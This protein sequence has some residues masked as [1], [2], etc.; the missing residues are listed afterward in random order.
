MA[1][2]CCS[3]RLFCHRM[4]GRPLRAELCR[5]MGLCW[6]IWSLGERTLLEYASPNLCKSDGYVHVHAVCNWQCGLP[7]GDVC[8]KRKNKLDIY[9]SFMCT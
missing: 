6:R 4:A 2:L 8:A 1:N 3:Y 7:L 5:R 9:V